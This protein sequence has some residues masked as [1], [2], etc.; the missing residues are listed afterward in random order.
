MWL[1][2]LHAWHRFPA[3]Q[4]LCI[5]KEFF[6]VIS[7][8]LPSFKHNFKRLG[9]YFSWVTELG[10]DITIS[11]VTLWHI[12]SKERWQSVAVLHSTVW[13][14]VVRFILAKHRYSWT[15]SDA[16]R[17]FKVCTTNGGVSTHKHQSLSYNN[18]NT[19]RCISSTQWTICLR[20]HNGI[21][22]W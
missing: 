12:G 3:K 13:T 19:C 9:K 18:L 2:I 20:D 8:F 15:V 4:K 14:I 6:R 10:K 22:W 5:L 17:D 1:L 16:I 21:A 11:V 7:C